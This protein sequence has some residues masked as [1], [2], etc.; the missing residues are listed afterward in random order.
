MP[1]RLPWNALKASSYWALMR[2][3]TR[4]LRRA[5]NSCASPWEKYAFRR[6]FR[7]S[8]RSSLQRRHPYAGAR[9]QP[10][11]KID[12][13][14]QVPARGDGL[15]TDRHGSGPYMPT[16]TDVF[17]KVRGHERSEQLRAAREA[18]LLP[19]F[20][21][22]ESPAAPGGR[23]GGRR[24]DHARLQQLPRAD[25][26]RAGDA[27][28]A[29]RARALRH[30]PHR[31]AAAQRDDRPAPRARARAGRVDGHRGGDRLH[32]RPPGQPRLPRHAA[33]AGRHG[34]RRLGRPRL[35][36]RRL[37]P[38]AGEAAPVPPRPAGQ[39]GED[40]R[41]RATTTAAACSSSSTAC[42]RWRAT[43]PTCRGSPSCAASTA[44]A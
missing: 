23:D 38:L 12:E 37:H 3:T 19:Y 36:P 26:R 28:R 24:A 15:D 32:H 27:G 20:R 33:R 31:L 41:P 1:Q 29:R 42:S 30:R 2:P 43:S 16:A 4:E 13:L 10:V 25:R 34:D 7:N 11:R 18:D 44:R 14:L 8:R 6:R 35:D 39:A 22:L 21:R 9:V 17:A 40:A 5:R